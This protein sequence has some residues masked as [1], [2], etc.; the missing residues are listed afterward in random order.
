VFVFNTLE[1][2][3]SLAQIFLASDRLGGS[4][5]L[6]ADAP[7]EQR[8]A[9]TQTYGAGNI[10]YRYAFR[11]QNVLC[12]IELD[13]PKG[14]FSIGDAARVAAVVDRRIRQALS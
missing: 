9:S 2:A 12:Y 14:K 4:A 8:Q 10:S 13:G 7:G 11:E 6:P 3:R 5:G 1:G